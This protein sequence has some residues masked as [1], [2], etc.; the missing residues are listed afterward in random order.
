VRARFEPDAPPN[1]LVKVVR[2][3]I[4]HR[5]EIRLVPHGEQWRGQHHAR[6]VFLGGSHFRT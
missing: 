3:R 5:V 4:G 1:T 2:L 6:L